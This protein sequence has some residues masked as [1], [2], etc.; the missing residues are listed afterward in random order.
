MVRRQLAAR[1][2]TDGRVLAA[3]A[4]VPRHRFVPPTLERAAYDDAP[5]PVGEAQTISQPY[6]VAL[7]TASMRPRRTHRVLEIGTGSGYQTAILAHLVRRVFTIERL[8]G[9]A[10]GARARLAALGCH[11]V[12]YRVGDGTLGWPEEAPF[13]G[14]VITAAAPLL[15]A[16]LIDQLA[17]GGRIVVPVGDRAL[18]ELLVAVNGPSGLKTYRA[19]ACRFVPLIGAHAFTP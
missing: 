14:I 11:N 17:P 7:M 13:D 15:P 2:I 12:E 6:M 8:Q 5:L 9:L 10:D 16:P 4:T 1:G 3:M 19:G 18:Q